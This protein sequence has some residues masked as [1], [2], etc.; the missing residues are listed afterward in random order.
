MKR[1][2]WTLIAGMLI[3]GLGLQ[4]I[5][6]QPLHR[7]I[8]TL[9]AEVSGLQTG[10]RQLADYRE[11][12]AG[13]NDLLSGL[14]AQNRHISSAREA[15]ENMR[16]LEREVMQQSHSADKAR[17]ALGRIARLQTGVIAQSK[18]TAAMQQSLDEIAECQQRA[19]QLADASG[20][21]LADLDQA[22]ESLRQLGDFQQRVS[23]EASG[24]SVAQ[25]R[26]AE[27]I[28]LKQ[29][30]EDLSPEAIDMAAARI[31]ELDALAQQ[32]INEGA[33]LAQARGVASELIALKQSIEQ[34]SPET[35]D[36]AGTRVCELEALT[37]QVI[38]QDQQIARARSTADELIALQDEILARG[39]RVDVAREHAE[40]LLRL[41]ELLA[42]DAGRDI[43]A[44]TRN[45]AGL[46]ELEEQLAMQDQKLAAAIESLEL[47]KDLQSEFVERTRELENIRRGL[48]ELILMESML[49]R[50]V[51]LLRPL[52][53][54]ADLRRLDGEQLQ[55]IAR[56]MMSGSEQRVAHNGG[57]A[58]RTQPVRMK[59]DIT[60]DDE[61][62]V[63]LPPA[64]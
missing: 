29:S 13:T 33:T 22:E 24:L 19:G 21:L 31:D 48:T 15:I 20:H 42:N 44:A 46:L 26:F 52:A 17:S 54:L 3:A 1:T 57:P 36:A 16:R 27:L 37:Q 53:E 64:E 59:D 45:L 38:D 56:S 50:T 39:V 25:K 8:E 10:M 32:M 49:A 63:P 41:E 62:L 47:L 2:T 61:A 14:A 5:V 58:G 28:A 23:L 51:R 18:R 6:T 12:V 4:L 35:I 11:E 40:R 43:E 30:I 7:Q 55:S 9:S 34:I 60:S